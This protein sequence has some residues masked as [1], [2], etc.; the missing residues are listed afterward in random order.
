M[1]TK[2]NF[3][4]ELEKIA[5]KFYSYGASDHAADRSGHASDNEDYFR[6][7]VEKIKDGLGCQQIKLKKQECPDSG[8]F[9]EFNYKHFDDVDWNSIRAGSMVAFSVTISNSEQRFIEL[10]ASELLNSPIFMKDRILDLN[11]VG[12]YGEFFGVEYKAQKNKSSKSIIVASFNSTCPS[13]TK[14]SSLK[15]IKLFHNLDSLTKKKDKMI[16]DCFFEEIQ[17]QISFS[18]YYMVVND[19]KISNKTQITYIFLCHG[20]FFAPNLEESIANILSKQKTANDMKMEFDLKRVKLRYRPFFEA[21]TIKA[22]GFGLYTSWKPKL[23]EVAREG[24]ERDALLNEILQIQQSFNSEEIDPLK[25]MD[26]VIYLNL[27]GERIRKRA[28]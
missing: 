16:K 7:V 3:E 5:E 1:L 20:N 15:N 2:Y 10:K 14:T 9:G 28:A 4:L 17:V 11:S 19:E 13:G 12:L 23:P 18:M 24:R 22:Q 6:S 26:N 21:P 8:I 27:T 25:G